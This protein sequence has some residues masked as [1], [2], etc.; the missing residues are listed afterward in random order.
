M[1]GDEASRTRVTGTGLGEPDG[2][3]ALEAA[4]AAGPAK[5]VR[6]A[7][8]AEAVKAPGPVKSPRLATAD[9]KP[10]SSGARTARR[11]MA[12]A[13]P[14]VW[15]TGVLVWELL[16]PVDTHCVALLAATPAL[17]CAGTGARTGVWLGGVCAFLAL[18]PLGSVP[19][20]EQIGGR[21]GM[22]G[23]IVCVA[24]ASCYSARR[25]ARL[26]DELARTREVATAAQQA[27]IRPLPARIGGFGVAAGYLSAT[28]GA[29]VGGDLYDA[30]ETAHGVRIVIGDVR[31]HG[32][33]AVST[34]AAVLGG[35]REAAHDEPRLERVPHRLELALDR[36]LAAR[37]S[38]PAVPPEPGGRARPAEE[39]PVDEEFVT[40]LLL[41]VHEDG[42]VRAVNCGHPWPYR[43]TAGHAGGCRSE[44]VCS[45]E[46]LPPLGMVPLP[47][48]GPEP[49]Q[50]ALPPGEVLF[51]YT[52]GAEDAR[53]AEGAFFPLPEALAAA[54]AG[55]RGRKGR[56][57][58]AGAADPLAPEG[59]V[60]SLRRCL[61]RHANGRLPDDVALLALR[62]DR[63]RVHGQRREPQPEQ[64]YFDEQLACSCP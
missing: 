2:A 1:T 39:E 23:A 19:A 12:F 24:M 9:G 59:I 21:A 37:H 42:T 33:G 15:A 5:A 52:D 20:Y 32:L 55:A 7:A 64:A 61:L 34:V 49:R 18:Y 43:L 46:P 6:T 13:V 44:P 10:S 38:P 41:E 48:D 26:I 40:V 29:A 45:E 3:R 22:S 25:R 60:D 50:L 4:N 57:A 8:H 27:L 31:G 14:A 62:N 58:T 28:R 17:A 53:D 35:F 47:P 56:R 30:V 16:L 36:H 51:L 11:A 54:V 63:C